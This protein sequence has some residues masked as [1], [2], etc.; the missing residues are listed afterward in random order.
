MD[1]LLIME[2]SDGKIGIYH[3]GPP[4]RAFVL[5][6]DDIKNILNKVN[7]KEIKCTLEDTKLSFMGIGAIKGSK[8]SIKEVLRRLNN[9]E[10]EN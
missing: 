8:T 2:R 5:S 7:D 4:P 6:V 3:R 1:K 10:L 9:Y